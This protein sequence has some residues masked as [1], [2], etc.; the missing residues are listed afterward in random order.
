MLRSLAGENSAVWADTV[1]LASNV[2]PPRL[3]RRKEALSLAPTRLKEA[4]MSIARHIEV[5]AES[6]KGFENACEQAIKDASETL[7]GIKQLYVK[8]VLCEGKDQNRIV[9]WR[10]NGR[11]YFV[12]EREKK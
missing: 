11:I 1:G 7:H 3:K 8:N 6:S 12:V 9:N 5:S 10:V 2:P 4:R